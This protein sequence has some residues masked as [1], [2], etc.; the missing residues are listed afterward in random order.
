MLEAVVNEHQ[1]LAMCLEILEERTGATLA[2]PVMAP[3]PFE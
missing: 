2:S 3:W 1:D